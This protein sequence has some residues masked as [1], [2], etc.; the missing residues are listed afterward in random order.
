[1]LAF[2]PKSRTATLN[3][4]SLFSSSGA[5]SSTYFSLVE[6]SFIQS[7]L[8]FPSSHN[9]FAFA[10]EIPS[11]LMRHLTIPD[12]LISLVI[13]LV[14]TLNTPGTFCSL[15]H[16]SIV[17]ALLLLEGI[18]QRSFTTSPKAWIPSDSLS[19]LLIP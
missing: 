8:S 2:T 17:F 11:V 4:S 18:S 12:F 7:P 6:T 14:S 1:M 9:S 15:S 13:F 3:A 5:A 19:I 10:R 16:S